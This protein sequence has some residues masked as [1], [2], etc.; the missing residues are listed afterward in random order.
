MSCLSL[1]SRELPLTQGEVKDHRM[2][3][4][5]SSLILVGCIAVIA[6]TINAISIHARYWEALLVGSGAGIFVTGC[7][8]VPLWPKHKENNHL[9]SDRSLEMRVS[10]VARDCQLNFAPNP[11]PEGRPPAEVPQGLAV[12]TAPSAVVNGASAPPPEDLAAVEI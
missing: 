3:I 8:L 4:L 7:W 9:E 6:T 11:I 12:G 5:G 10:R 2:S 1:R